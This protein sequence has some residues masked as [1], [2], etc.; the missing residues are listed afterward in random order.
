MLSS[1]SINSQTRTCLSPTKKLPD[2]ALLFG[3]GGVM[4]SSLIPEISLADSDGYSTSTYNRESGF[5]GVMYPT[6]QP[7]IVGG[8]VSSVEQKK[9]RS[10]I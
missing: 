5:A 10:E 3:S 6:G 7:V 1:L 4:R 8:V 2:R 9:R